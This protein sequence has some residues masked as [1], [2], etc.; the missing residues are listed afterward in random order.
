MSTAKF[1]I[2]VRY[3]V[4]CACHRS[5]LRFPWPMFI[6]YAV[7][8]ENLK[9]LDS[10]RTSGDAFWLTRGELIIT[11][12]YV[13]FILFN[14]RCAYTTYHCVTFVGD[15]LDRLRNYSLSA[16]RTRGTREIVPYFENV[17]V[18]TG[19][20]FWRPDTPATCNVM[21]WWFVIRRVQCICVRFIVLI[22]Y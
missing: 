20:G 4:Q 8:L 5:G 19:H 21:R 14:D 17:F 3:P 2:A 6:T 18:P 22:L 15:V 1:A 7:R 10:R 16:V 12:H 13:I 11:I 9:A